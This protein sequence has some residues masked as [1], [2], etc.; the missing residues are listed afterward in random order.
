MTPFSTRTRSLTPSAG[1]APTTFDDS[2]LLAPAGVIRSS[3]EAVNVALKSSTKM[4]PVP[5]TAIEYGPF[6]AGPPPSARA[7]DQRPDAGVPVHPDDLG[8]AGGDAFVGRHHVPVQVEG[9]VLRAVQVRSSERGQVVGQG[10]LARGGSE[11]DHLTLTP[12]VWTVDLVADQCLQG[13]AQR[14]QA[15]RHRRARLGQGRAQHPAPQSDGQRRTGSQDHR[16]APPRNASLALH[17][18][19][20][21]SRCRA[22][23][24]DVPELRRRTRG[25]FAGQAG[26]VT[27]ASP[28]R[29][30]ASPVR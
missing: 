18:P 21:F 22:V 10:A 20:A 23:L 13:R 2:T 12:R 25:R 1:P 28:S 16:L 30:T 29:R 19:S 24:R 14:R 27:Q 7:R 26:V 8:D 17:F 9:H 11:L 3:R 15:R 6:K 5:S 4:L